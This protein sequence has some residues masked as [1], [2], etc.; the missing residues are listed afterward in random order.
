MIL[1]FQI[2]AVVGSAAFA[3]VMLAIALILGPFWR[4]LPP[5]D[6]LTWFAAN[7]GLIVRTIPLVVGP[8]I[9][10]LVGSIVL[11]WGDASIRNLW[12]A[13]LGC[14]AVLLGLTVAYFFPINATFNQ[15][16]IA[17][18]DVPGQLDAWLAVHWVRIV[19]ALAAA[20]FGLVAATR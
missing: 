20:V 8:T 16:A 3:G 1:P 2:L 5:A 10:G 18:D 17:V 4:S 15:G 6:F 14:I 12:L 7:S 9:F 11:S 13:A 19:L